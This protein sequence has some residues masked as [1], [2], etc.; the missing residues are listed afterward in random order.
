MNRTCYDLSPTTNESSQVSARMVRIS[1]SIVFAEVCR[2]LLAQ[3]NS[4][5]AVMISEFEVKTNDLG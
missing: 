2:P 3:T 4:K 5:Q 1:S